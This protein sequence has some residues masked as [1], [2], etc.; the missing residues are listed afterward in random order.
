VSTLV[1]M[2]PPFT[3]DG[4]PEAWAE[5]IL[6]LHDAP[7]ILAPHGVI[8]AVV[9]RIVMTGKSRLVRKVR[10]L[11]IPHYGFSECDRDA[12]CPVGAKLSTTLLMIEQLG[13]AA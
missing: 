5:H 12:F 6:A 4:R 1:I 7:H 2:N 11:V 8:S 3:L 9:P 13:G 10:D